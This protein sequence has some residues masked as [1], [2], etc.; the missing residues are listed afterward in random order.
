MDPESGTPR[1]PIRC[2]IVDFPEPL[3]PITHRVCPSDT[4]SETRSRAGTDV[5][6]WRYVFTTSASRIILSPLASLVLQSLGDAQAR[7]RASRE[8]AGRRR[9]PDRRRE[10]EKGRGRRIAVQRLNA[11][12]VRKERADRHVAEKRPPGD[13]D[14]RSGEADDRRLDDHESAHGGPPRPDRA[15]HAELARAGENRGEQRIDHA[16]ERD[17]GYAAATDCAMSSSFSRRSSSTVIA[18][19]PTSSSHS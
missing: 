19:S 8:I 7:R 11:E 5:R 15:Q 2:S 9:Q 16:E 1:P 14:E 10:R 17:R 4:S 6:P 13:A 18:K 12:H 3:A